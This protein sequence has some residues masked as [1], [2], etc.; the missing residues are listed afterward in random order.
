MR[1]NMQ[2]L[3]V[4]EVDAEAR[5]KTVLVVDDEAPIRELISVMLELEGHRVLQA[6]DGNRALEIAAEEYLDLVTLDVM[7]PGLDGWE[8]AAA[9]DADP[10]LSA[11][12]RLM[13]SGMAMPQLRA[14]PGAARASAVLA[15]PFDF[16]EFT[17]IVAMLLAKPVAVPGP[18]PSSHDD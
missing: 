11:V 6:E 1:T 3:P 10:R 17:E 9:M 2:E 15:K 16:A 14:A 8:V 12:P 7:M 13:V 4:D 18:R 5:Q